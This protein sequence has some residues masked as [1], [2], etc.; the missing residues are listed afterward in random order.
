MDGNQLE[1]R[2]RRYLGNFYFSRYEEKQQLKISQIV[3][4]LNKSIS[5][6]SREEKEEDFQQGN[7]TV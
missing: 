7:E 4:N 3:K 6:E 1:I 5:N 2:E